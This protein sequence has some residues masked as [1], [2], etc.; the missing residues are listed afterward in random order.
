MQE[1]QPGNHGFLLHKS[2]DIFS[3][4]YQKKKKK[5][6]KKKIWFFTLNHL[7]DS[8]H[9]II[10]VLGFISLLLKGNIIKFCVVPYV[11][12]CL[13]C[14]LQCVVVVLVKTLQ[15]Y[16]HHHFHHQT[17]HHLFLL[18]LMMLQTLKQEHD[19]K[20]YHW[21]HLVGKPTIWFFNRSENK[22]VGAVTETGLKLE[23]LDLKRRVSVLSV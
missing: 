15:T 22:P 19:E 8:K 18:L 1:N 20:Y 7:N 14:F 4:K 16:H 5:K 11:C 13:P 3:P 2:I 9:G 6:K 10:G 21:S 17:Y 23:I 12:V